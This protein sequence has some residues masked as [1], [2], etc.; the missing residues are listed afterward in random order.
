MNE[1]GVDAVAKLIEDA[2]WSYPVSTRRLMNEYALNNVEIDSAGNT[3]MIGEL[4]DPS[5]FREF[6]SREDLEQKLGPVFERHRDERR[7]GIVERIQQ[8][9]R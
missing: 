2:G 3:A 6:T 4:V 8:Y 1:R 9:F 5:D 7:T